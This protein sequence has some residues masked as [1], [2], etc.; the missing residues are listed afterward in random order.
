[1]FVCCKCCILSGR[2][3]CYELIIHPE[4]SYR[5]WCVILY[6]LETSRMRRLWPA[7]GRSATEKKSFIMHQGKTNLQSRFP[8]RQNSLQG[9][10]WA[11]TLRNWYTELEA[12]M[13][14]PNFD[15]QTQQFLFLYFSPVCV[16]RKRVEAISVVI[17]IW[18]FFSDLVLFL[19]KIM[20]RL[21][22][23]IIDP[24]INSIIH[25]ASDFSPNFY[26]HSVQHYD[27]DKG[28]TRLELCGRTI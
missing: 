5:T 17:D 26:Y 8:A 20:P 23:L 21:L 6:D 22:S 27:I 16:S 4:E 28:G 10:C 3:L 14:W 24:P 11:F 18:Y 25:P 2:D 12:C 13:E 15:V 9:N 1:M 19:G 7:L